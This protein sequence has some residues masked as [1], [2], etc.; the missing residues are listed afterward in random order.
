MLL[1]WMA[2]EL[3]SLAL[4]AARGGSEQAVDQGLLAGTRQALDGKLALHGG[5][6]VGL[7]LDID[8]L[9]RT[10]RARVARTAPGVV[11]LEAA[12]GVG[13]PAGVEAAVG[14]LDDVAIARRRRGDYRRG[15]FCR[16]GSGHRERT[17]ASIALVVC[18][19][20]AIL[21]SVT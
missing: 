13:R 21:V 5:I 8:E 14:A 20:L 2:E 7:R 17:A 16:A 9:H 11:R 1:Q 10:A 6:A 19:R 3:A 15:S 12:V 18:I 4:A